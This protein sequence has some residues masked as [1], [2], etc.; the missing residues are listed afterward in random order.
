[1]ENLNIFNLKNMSEYDARKSNSQ[2]LA[3]IGDAIYSLYAR[4][5][6]V[7]NYSKKINELHALTTKIV[8]ASGQSEFVEKLIPLLTQEELEVYKRARNYKTANIAKNAKVN[9]Y[10]KATGLEAVLGY[11]YLYG[12]IERH[13]CQ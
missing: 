7:L 9:D 12:N 5:Q 13:G 8:K 10:K 1:M 2:M 11:L 6:V 4:N 3:F